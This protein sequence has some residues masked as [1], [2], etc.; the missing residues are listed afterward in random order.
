MFLVFLGF[1]PLAPHKW[2]VFIKLIKKG[3]GEKQNRKLFAFLSD[4]GESRPSP[5][6]PQCELPLGLWLWLEEQWGWWEERSSEEMEEGRQRP[7]SRS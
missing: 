5:S 2:E 7:F 4:T 3:P 6:F 1:I